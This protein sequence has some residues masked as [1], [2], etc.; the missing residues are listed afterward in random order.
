MAHRKNSGLPDAASERCFAVA[1]NL[2]KISS[3]MRTRYIFPLILAKAIMEYLEQV[4]LLVN[5]KQGIPLSSSLP[6]TK[7]ISFRD[8]WVCIGIHHFLSSQK[9]KK[10]QTQKKVHSLGIFEEHNSYC[11]KSLS[12]PLIRWLNL[13]QSNL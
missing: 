11:L 9:K 7:L 13:L 6:L 8:E 1:A 2:C 4:L 10:I 5:L 3:R 12:D